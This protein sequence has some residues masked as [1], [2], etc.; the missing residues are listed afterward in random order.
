MTLTM[1]T[2][3]VLVAVLGPSLALVLLLRLLVL[4]L[5]GVLV[6]ESVFSWEVDTTNGKRHRENEGDDA[7][8]GSWATRKMLATRWRHVLR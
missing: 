1:T 3:F 8:Q 4:V 5:N 7:G 6:V 2:E